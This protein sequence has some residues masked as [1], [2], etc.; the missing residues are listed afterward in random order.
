MNQ[1]LKVGIAGFGYSSKVFH[2]PFLVQ[3]TRFNIVK[4]YERSTSNALAVLPNVEIVREFDG[5]LSD[6]ID[7]II[8]TTPNQTHYSLAKQAILAG[9]HVLVEKPLV[10]TAEQALELDALA[11]QHNVILSVYQN[12]RWDHATATAKQILAQ[13]LIGEA[14]DCEIRFERYAKGKNA[15]AWKETGEKGTGLV[16]DLGV[17]LID[18]SLYLFGMPNAVF[19]DIRYQHK[20]ALSDDNFTIHLYY[21]SGLKVALYATKYAREAGKHFVLHGKL[22]SY[23]KQNVDCQESLLTSGMI[24]QKNYNLES[25]QDW[26]ILHTEM[27]GEVVRQP[28]NNADTSYQA[29]YDNLY[30]AITENESLAVTAEQAAKVLYIIEKAFESAVSGK[31]VNIL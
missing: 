8:I 1:I 2:V 14:V 17:H 18:A 6:E 3:D 7:L 21:D 26:G 29:L 28:F 22:G 12:R 11:K 10:I 9:K 20:G 25:E 15:K 23:V 30:L 4:V 31:K 19:A 13:G 24:P 16:Y 5:L 27:N